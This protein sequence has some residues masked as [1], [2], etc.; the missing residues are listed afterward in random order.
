MKRI[1]FIILC[2]CYINSTAWAGDTSTIKVTNFTKVPNTDGYSLQGWTK[3]GTKIKAINVS[4]DENVEIDPTTGAKNI[5]IPGSRFQGMQWYSIAHDAGKILFTKPNDFALYIMNIDGTNVKKIWSEDFM[6]VRMFPDGAKLL[7]LVRSPQHKNERGI[8][9]FTDIVI[10]SLD[11]TVLKRFE[12][13]TG[14]DAEGY[15]VGP[16]DLNISPDG[17]KIAFDSGLINADGTGYKAVDGL[18]PA[19]WSEDGQ[20]IISQGGCVFKS[21]GTEIS[22]KRWDSVDTTTSADYN[23]YLKVEMDHYETD[24]LGSK[25]YVSDRS[26]SGERM[27]FDTQKD[28]NVVVIGLL[29]SPQNDKIAFKAADGKGIYTVNVSY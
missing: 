8:G 29:I 13:I 16:R 20:Y 7:L 25:L 12:V 27:L 19:F 1:I 2:F 9:R 5:L 23:F 26:G 10:I 3:D 6:Y 21:D 22:C 17:T 28:F 11:G 15:A 14:R 24:Y 4:T 18:F